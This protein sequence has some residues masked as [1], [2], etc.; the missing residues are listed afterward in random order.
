MQFCAFANNPLGW[1]VPVFFV[2]VLVFIAAAVGTLANWRWGVVALSATAFFVQQVLAISAASTG[3]A[4]AVVLP[5]VVLEIL[6]FIGP[7]RGSGWAWLNDTTP[8]RTP[9]PVTWACVIVALKSGFGTALVAYLRGY[10]IL[11]SRYG[12]DTGV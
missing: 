1:A 7:F 8:P 6:L 5:A 3:T 9:R 11:F 10:V 12:G 4:L 2:S